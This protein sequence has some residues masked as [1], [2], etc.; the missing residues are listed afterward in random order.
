MTEIGTYLV[1]VT[2]LADVWMS[3]VT[4]R[5]GAKTTASMLAPPTEIE[6]TGEGDMGGGNGRKTSVYNWNNPMSINRRMDE[7]SE[8]HPHNEILQP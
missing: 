2:R 7:Q 6:M 4:P 8:V 5:F 1:N 3:D